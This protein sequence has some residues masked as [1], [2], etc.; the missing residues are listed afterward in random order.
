MPA[1]PAPSCDAGS[2]TKTTVPVACPLDCPDRCAMDAVVSDGRLLQLKGSRR[3][4][5]TG[6]YICKKVQDWPARVHGADRVLH[7]A[8]R[9][10]PK[11]PGARFEPIS[12]SEALDTLAGR[13]GALV[14]QGRGGAIQPVWYGG[15]NGLITGGAMDQRFWARI[16]ARGLERTLCAANTAAAVA[17]VWPGLPSASQE[18]VELATTAVVWGFNPHASGIHLVERLNAL[19]ARGGAVVVVDPRA[20]PSVRGALHL[21]LLPGTDFGLAMSLLHIALRDGFVD[22]GWLRAQVD[23]AEAVAPRVE[24]WTPARAAAICGVEAG[25]IEEMARI[26]RAG[27]PSFIRCGWGPERNQRG[28]LAYEAM[29]MLPAFY[30]HLGRPGGGYSLSTSA[31][32]GMDK[33]LLSGIPNPRPAPPRP[34]NLSR[35]ADALATEDDPRLELVYVYNCNPV[36]TVPDQVSLVRELRQPDRFVVVHEQ[37]WTD[38]TDEADLVLPATT[39]VEHADLS[40]SY[41]GYTLHWS[42]PAIPP[43]GEARSNHAV[44]Q[45]LAERLGFG[46]EAAFRDS[47]ADI[48]ARV[49]TAAFGADTWAT[50]QSTGTVDLPRKIQLQDVFPSRRPD[51]SGLLEEATAPTRDRERA[52]HLISPACTAAISST[53]FERQ[54]AGSGRLSLSPGDAARL[55][56]RSGDPVRVT[57]SLGEVDIIATIDLAHRDGVAAIPKGLWRKHSLNGWTANALAP[58]EVDARGGGACYND[59]RVD[60]RRLSRT[61]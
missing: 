38:T 21:P 17:R 58:A 26:Y 28:V 60:V 34:T 13:M 1:L 50:L 4:R 3:S 2:T 48:A 37:V 22:W 56:V 18:D 14:E 43:V 44:F 49:I 45:A 24:G 52:L 6:G 20:I 11:G 35:L 10:G 39:F 27:A 55:G 23:G 31:G 42:V 12:W 47:E 41:G 16:G 46:D 51:W 59:A 40:R 25:L 5:W 32:Y 7:P 29:L 33:A 30:G 9:V 53:G 19:K 54:P 15:S 61:P 8:R 36:A 57:S